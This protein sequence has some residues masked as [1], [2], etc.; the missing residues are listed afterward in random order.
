MVGVEVRQDDQGDSID[1]Q[2]VEALVHQR[3]I[4]ACVDD[5]HRPSPGVEDQPVALADVAHHHQPVV[6]RPAP[7]AERSHDRQKQDQH[8]DEAAPGVAQ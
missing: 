3:R 1:V 2:P 4:W 5:D 6:R 7:R 8:D